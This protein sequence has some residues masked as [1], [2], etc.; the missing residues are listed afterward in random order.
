MGPI[1]TFPKG[2]E[3]H[4]TTSNTAGRSSRPLGRA[5]EGLSEGMG[6]GLRKQQQL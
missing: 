3:R 5:G 2:K 1:L 4:A 6:R